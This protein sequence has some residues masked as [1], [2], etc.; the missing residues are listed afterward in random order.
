MSIFSVSEVLQFAVGMEEAGEKFYR[1]LSSNFKEETLQNVFNFLAEEECKHREVFA[2]M[3]LEVEKYEPPENYPQEYFSYLRAY[4]DQ[5][6]F[7]N[8]L[9]EEARQSLRSLLSALDFAMRRELD[10]ILYY[11]ELKGAVPEGEHSVVD[12]VIEEERKHFLKLLEI[13]KRL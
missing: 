8:K 5:V 9:E 10:S 4:A 1:Q 3:A 7:S 12:M 2:N 13:K 6:I 11:Q